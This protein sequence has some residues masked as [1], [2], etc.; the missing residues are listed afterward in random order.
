[1]VISIAAAGL[2]SNQDVA[3]GLA[4]LKLHDEGAENEKQHMRYS[5]HN[6]WFDARPA[7]HHRQSLPRARTEVA[8]HWGK[9]QA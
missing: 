6:F 7:P 5:S 8:R 3:E 9:W 1:M 4:G 2:A